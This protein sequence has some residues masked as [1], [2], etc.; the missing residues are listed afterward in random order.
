MFDI[1]LSFHLY[2]AIQP[3]NEVVSV[4][5]PLLLTQPATEPGSELSA[6]LFIH[7]KTRIE[8]GT[9]FTSRR[10][11]RFETYR[12]CDRRIHAYFTSTPYVPTTLV[13]LC[14]NLPMGAN[15][16][17]SFV[18]VKDRWWW[19]LTC[20]PC[21]I[22]QLLLN[23]ARFIGLAFCILWKGNSLWI[24]KSICFCYIH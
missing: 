20:A 16:V 6:H 14:N 19:V 24:V 11:D 10:K 9:F 17:A 13:P 5:K 12:I 8:I 2:W 15:I 21:V 1:N 18:H 7:S 22:C 3:P 4:H 23:L